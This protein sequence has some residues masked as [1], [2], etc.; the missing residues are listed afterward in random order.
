MPSNTVLISGPAVGAAQ[1]LIWSY[2]S[3]CS[4]LQCPQLSELVHFLLRELS[5]TFIY[6]IDTELPGWSC[7]FHLLLL[8][9]VGGFWVFFLSHTAPEFHLWFYFHLC[10]GSSTGVCSWGCSGGLGSAP[11]RARSGG[12]AAAWVAGTL[13]IPSVQGHGLPPP[14][15]LRPYQSLLSS[16]F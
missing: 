13:A 5:M 2:S 7:G 16:L 12:G 14:Q 4:G 9:L 10:M 8:Q 11:V 6:S 15:E 1:I 3:L